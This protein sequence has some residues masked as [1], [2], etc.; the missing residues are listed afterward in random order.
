MIGWV[1]VWN[2]ILFEFSISDKREKIKREE[3]PKPG[4]V[5]TGHPIIYVNKCNQSA[6]GSFLLERQ[7]TASL[8]FLI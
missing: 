7:L 4:Q 3:S 6:I 2:S 5:K 1:E 8:S